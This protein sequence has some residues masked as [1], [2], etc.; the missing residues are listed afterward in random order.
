M[1][2]AVLLTGKGSNTYKDKNI[3]P[4]KGK[5]LMAYPAQAA[6]ASK[7]I[8]KFY[9]SSENKKIL[10]IAHDLGYEKIIRPQEIAQAD[11]QH[12]DAITHALKV[13]KERDE[14]VPDILVVVLANN[15]TIKTEWID[16]CIRLVM[17]DTDI[18]SVVPVYNDND[19]HPFRAKKLNADGLLEPFFDFSSKNI[20]TNRQDL[21][22]C[23][24]LCHNFWTLNISKS[25]FT[26]NGQQ[27]WQFMGNKIKH[28]E[29]ETSIDV[30]DDTDILLCELWLDNR[31]AYK[32]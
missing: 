16:D 22:D 29:V 1:K 24:F 2:I 6:K 14:Y 3:L 23:Y 30:H 10:D 12:I 20:S 11:S 5:P 31:L 18:S 21:E 32:H 25:I 9:V 4:V 7:L 15:I 17:D 19:H 27:P 28:Y 26:D 13:M 8:Q